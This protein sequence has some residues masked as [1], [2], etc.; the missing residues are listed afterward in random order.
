[1]GGS[2][3]HSHTHTVT[4]KRAPTDESV[5]L[6]REMNAAA[7]QEII[8]AIR[9]ENCAIECIVHILNNHLNG[10]IDFIVIYKLNG[11]Q[12]SVE[13]SSKTF[14]NEEKTITGVIDAVARD[15][16]VNTLVKPFNTALR[17]APWTFK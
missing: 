15:I 8:T 13:Y 11:V 7:K 12:R 5:K 2:E 10:T 9:V 1:M 16:V 6:L 17:N 3:H 4:E 14:D